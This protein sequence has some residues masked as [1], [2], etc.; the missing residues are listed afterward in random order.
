MDMRAC[1]YTPSTI[2][3]RERHS[4]ERDY[5]ALYMPQIHFSPY[6]WPGHEQFACRAAAEGLAVAHSKLR[7]DASDKLWLPLLGP[8]ALFITAFF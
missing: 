2:T 1:C 6:M 8:A 7:K 3:E 4:R 5:N